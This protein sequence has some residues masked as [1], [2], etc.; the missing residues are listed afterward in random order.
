[1]NSSL[2]LPALLLISLALMSAAGCANNSSTLPPAAPQVVKE[3]EIPP[4]TEVQ[5]KLPLP[6]G[7]YLKRVEQREEAMEQSLKAL[8]ASSAP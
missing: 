3:V 1:M 7:A 5:R 6:S 2:K 4:L 8:R